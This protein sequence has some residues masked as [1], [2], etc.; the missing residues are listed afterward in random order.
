MEEKDKIKKMFVILFL[1]ITAALGGVYAQQNEG[2]TANID[3]D[4]MSVIISV[5]LRCQ[6]LLHGLK[7]P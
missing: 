6:S 3:T 5:N 1:L 4:K 7:K 2:T